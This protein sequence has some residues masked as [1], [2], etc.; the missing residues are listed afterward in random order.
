LCKQ[1]Q[2]AAAA[3]RVTD[4]ARHDRAAGV[5]QCWRLVHDVPLKASRA[6]VPVTGM[7][8]GEIGPAQV[9]HCSGGTDLRVS[10][11][12]VYQLMR[13]GR[14]RGK[15]E[16]ETFQTL[17]NQ[18]DHFEHHYGPGEQHLSVVFATLMRLALLVDQTQQRCCALLQAVWAK[19]GSNRLRWERMRALC[20]DDALESRQELL[21]A[22]WYGLKQFKPSVACDA[23]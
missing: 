13:G 2:A 20:S 15:I 22:L 12:H 6:D 16:H 21:E 18:G 5:I 3:G 10:Q 1:V 17:N 8:Y 11:R 14:A 23:S 19:L 7:A 9:Q 4:D